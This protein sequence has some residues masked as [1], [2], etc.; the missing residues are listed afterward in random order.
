M[1]KNKDKNST[2]CKARLLNEASQ[3]SVLQLKHYFSKRGVTHKK[4]DSSHESP[5]GDIVTAEY[6]RGYN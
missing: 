6:V 3:H 1:L 2:E 4:V 5:L